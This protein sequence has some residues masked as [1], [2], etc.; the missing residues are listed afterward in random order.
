MKKKRLKI[1]K[2]KREEVYTKTENFSGDYPVLLATP[3]PMLDHKISAGLSN[4]IAGVVAR[5]VALPMTLDSRAPENAR[6]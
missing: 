3:V 4:F 2:R 5:K 6:C 1:K